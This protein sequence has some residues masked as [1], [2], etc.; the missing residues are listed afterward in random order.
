MFDI[1]RKSHGELKM[2]VQTALFL[3]NVK[4][5]DDLEVSVPAVVVGREFMF[6]FSQFLA[7]LGL[8]SDARVDVVRKIAELY[9]EYESYLGR[10]IMKSRNKQV[11]DDEDELFEGWDTSCLQQTTAYKYL[12][13]IFGDRL[14]RVLSEAHFGIKRSLVSKNLAQAMLLSAVSTDNEFFKILTDTK[15]TI[16]KQVV[17]DIMKNIQ[18]VFTEVSLSENYDSVVQSIRNGVNTQFFRRLSALKAAFQERQSPSIIMTK[19]EVMRQMLSFFTD[20]EPDYTYKRHNNNLFEKVESIDNTLKD[21]PRSAF[22]VFYLSMLRC[23]SNGGND[24]APQYSETTLANYLRMHYLSMPFY[25]DIPK[26]LTDSALLNHPVNDQEIAAVEKFFFKQMA[27]RLIECVVTGNNDGPLKA[28]IQSLIR[29]RSFKAGDIETVLVNRNLTLLSYAHLA[30]M[31]AL[32]DVKNCANTTN[33]CFPY[34]E[35]WKIGLI[36]TW[37]ETATKNESTKYLP[38]NHSRS[39]AEPSEIIG[40]YSD[41]NLDSIEFPSYFF[42]D[43]LQDNYD[44]LKYSVYSDMYRG[45]VLRKK[46]L[47]GYLEDIPA[48]IPPQLIRLKINDDQFQLINKKPLYYVKGSLKF[49]MIETQAG[50]IAF[51]QMNPYVLHQAK[52]LK[53]AKRMCSETFYV[54]AADF[55]RA[56]G[57]SL[58]AAHELLNITISQSQVDKY[59]PFGTL[60]N[61]TSDV[62]VDEL[63]NNDWTDGFSFLYSLTYEGPLESIIYWDPETAPIYEFGSAP[64][65]ALPYI[66]QY[67]DYYPAFCYIEDSGFSKEDALISKFLKGDKTALDGMKVPQ[68]KDLSDSE[69]TKDIDESLKANYPKKD[70]SVGENGVIAS[71]PDT[72]EIEKKDLV[73]EESFE[74]FAKKKNKNKF[75]VNSRTEDEKS[76]DPLEEASKS[77]EEKK[78]A[79]EESVKENKSSKKNRSKGKGAIEI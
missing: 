23:W 44:A 8:A 42:D 38:G 22:M 59:K 64:Q 18:N 30:L 4:V 77:V 68:N 72:K 35:E 28:R 37:W 50:I 75:I 66:K 70:E 60:I 11:D 9:T 43:D 34:E 26:E 46:P 21:V 12:E 15:T 6:D 7:Q 17:L 3:H 54:N 74:E 31:S 45:W 2:P 27:K 20:I 24:Y 73:P 78:K 55:A 52:I 41:L 71:A 48:E 19:S 56:K 39:I 51:R 29:D 16:N 58:K 67:K 76:N 61:N 13:E 63:T 69:V 57:I 1:V 14:P 36:K 53:W 65:I 79:E 25:V 10:P 33:V 49:P 40:T 62:I 47:E 32:D 5:R